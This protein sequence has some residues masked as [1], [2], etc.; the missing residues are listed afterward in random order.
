MYNYSLYYK[1]ILTTKYNKILV[2]CIY[3]LYTNSK[4]DDINKT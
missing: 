1:F 2:N 3:L 4:G